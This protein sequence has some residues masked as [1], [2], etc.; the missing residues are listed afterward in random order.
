MKHTWN[1]S[2]SGV[3][4]TGGSAAQGTRAGSSARPG[5]GK[6]PIATSAP[7]DMHGLSRK[8]STEVLK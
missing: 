3:K 2:S 6:F 5:K 1:K 8:P 7:G 4:G